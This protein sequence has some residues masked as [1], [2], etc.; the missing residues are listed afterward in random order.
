MNEEQVMGTNLMPKQ[1]VVAIQWNSDTKDFSMAKPNI[2][3]EVV[4]KKKCSTMR[5]QQKYRKAWEYYPEFE[6]WLESDDTNVYKA[7]CKMCCKVMVADLSVLQLHAIAKKHIKI[8][9]DFN[10]AKAALESL[11]PM[12]SGR[13]NLPTSR[14]MTKMRSQKPFL[15]DNPNDISV[16]SLTLTGWQT[17]IILVV[18]RTQIAN[19]AVL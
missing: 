2:P 9:E 4:P 15:P 19:K 3:E 17:F 13:A 7:R 10:K 8:C 14:K 5:K 11:S 16:E 6:Q 18:N 12:Q 1:E